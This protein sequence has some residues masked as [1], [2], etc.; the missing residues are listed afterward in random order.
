M[1]YFETFVHY[2]A[3]FIDNILPQLTKLIHNH[4]IEIELNKLG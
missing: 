3:E 2:I 1:I 4:N